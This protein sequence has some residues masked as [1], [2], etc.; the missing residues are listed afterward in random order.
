MGGGGA[1][2][3][4]EHSRQIAKELK[5]GVPGTGYG[6]TETNGLG[7]SISGADLLERGRSCGRPIPPMVDDQDRRPQRSRSAAR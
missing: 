3:A 1:A 4:P 7:S 2:M 5:S 6:M